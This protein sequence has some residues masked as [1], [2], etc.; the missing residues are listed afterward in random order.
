MTQTVQL[1][2]LPPPDKR[3]FRICGICRQIGLIPHTC[4][5]GCEHVCDRCREQFQ[6]FRATRTDILPYL[7]IVSTP[8]F[9]GG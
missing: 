6:Q 4:K 7:P 8:S 5:C 1:I 3:T 9:H 2:Q